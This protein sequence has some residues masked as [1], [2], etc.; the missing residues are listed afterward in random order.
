[1]WP[2]ILE[3]FS[4]ELSTKAY[5]EENVREQIEDDMEFFY[6]NSAGGRRK[7]KT[8]NRHFLCHFFTFNKSHTASVG[9]LLSFYSF[10]S[11]AFRRFDQFNSSCTLQ[12]T[13]RAGV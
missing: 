13:L 4:V 5:L 1:M 6:D 9:I 10:K 8:D 12:M 2:S 3:S 7:N 11:T